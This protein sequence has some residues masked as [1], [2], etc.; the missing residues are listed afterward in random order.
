M[1]IPVQ[2]PRIKALLLFHGGAFATRYKMRRRPPWYLCGVIRPEKRP[3]SQTL[4]RSGNPTPFAWDVVETGVKY[5]KVEV[6]YEL[7]SLDGIV[8]LMDLFFIPLQRTKHCFMCSMTCLTCKFSSC[9]S[10]VLWLYRQLKQ[11]YKLLKRNM[12]TYQLKHLH[13]Q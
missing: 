3:F 9:I 13:A 8:N 5:E 10:V 7:T 1:S 4:T 11:S 6:S 2:Y 12:T